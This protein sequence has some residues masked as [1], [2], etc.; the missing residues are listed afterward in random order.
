MTSHEAAPLHRQPDASPSLQNSS[1]N[2]D[3]DLY[4]VL[5]ENETVPDATLHRGLSTHRNGMCANDEP[6]GLH[7]TYSGPQIS[8][9]QDQAI[10]FCPIKKP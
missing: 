8:S 1:T 9:T 6:P 5:K 7:R 3:I 10:D 4:K 2:T